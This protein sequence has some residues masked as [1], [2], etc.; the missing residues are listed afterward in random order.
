VRWTPHY[1]ER[2]ADAITVCLCLTV[3]LL[4]FFLSLVL[5]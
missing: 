4:T 1:W 2:F 5:F 3:L